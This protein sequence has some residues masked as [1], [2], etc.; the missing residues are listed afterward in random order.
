[1]K[2]LIAA[3]AACICLP[4]GVAPPAGANQYTKCELAFSM[5][6]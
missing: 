3:V 6:G 2:A 1:M 5:N 4:L